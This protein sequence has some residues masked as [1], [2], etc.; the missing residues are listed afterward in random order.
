LPLLGLSLT[1]IFSGVVGFLVLGNVL[2][3]ILVMVGLLLAVGSIAAY[4]RRSSKRQRPIT[5]IEDWDTG[6]YSL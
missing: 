4:R 1:G 3:A 2:I 5:L 6:P